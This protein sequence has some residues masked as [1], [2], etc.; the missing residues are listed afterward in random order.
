MVWTDHK[1]LEYI[2]SA[3]RLNARQVRWALFFTRFQFTITYRPG[4]R[5]TKPDALSRQFTV[6]EDVARDSPIL[7]PTCVIGTLTWEIESAIKEAQRTEPDP[8][9]GP[10]GSLFVP[11]QV[12]LI[13]P[14]LPATQGSTAPSH[15]SNVSPGGPPSPTTS[16]STS[17]PVQSARRTRLLTNLR[18]S[19]PASTYTKPPLVTYRYRLCDR[20][21]TIFR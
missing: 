4:S 3:K 21:T 5:N 18:W 17:L 6:S 11:Y 10:P 1:N 19:A 9:T 7:P 2:R 20:P 14:S 12:G 16:V 15:S 8:G 13:P